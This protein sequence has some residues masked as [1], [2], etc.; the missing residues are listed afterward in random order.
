MILALVIAC[1][2]GGTEGAPSPVPSAAVAGPPGGHAPMGGM[3]GGA[4]AEDLAGSWDVSLAAEVPALQDAAT[5]PDAD[6]DGATDAW[7]CPLSGTDC[8]DADPRVTPE[9]ERWVRPGPFLMG[10]TS[11]QAG[12]DEGPVHVVQLSGYCLDRRERIGTDGALVAGVDRSAA[13]TMCEADGKT[14]PTEA[15]WEK[16]ARGG[17]EL[18]SDAARCDTGDLRP[19]PWGFDVPACARANHQESTGAPRMCEGGATLAVRNTGPYGHDELAGNLWE[20]TLDRYHPQVYRRAPARVD[21]LGPA[22]GDLHVLRGGGWNTF[23]T[24][25]RVANRL[26][27]NLE[28]T[29]T[30][31]RCARVRAKGTYDEVAPLEVVTISGEVRGGEGPL[32]GAALYVTAFD[33]SDADPA[34]GAVAPGRSPA[35]E[36]RLTPNGASTVPFRLEVPVDGT[37]VVMGALDGGAPL[38]TN[39]QWVAQSGAGGMGRAEP[40][41]VRVG[42]DDVSAVV[43]TIRAFE[44]GGPPGEG[45]PGRGPVPPPSPPNAGR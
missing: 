16:A 8:D 6:G 12:R 15:Q 2:S 29:A 20:W 36:V 42:R 19:Y 40:N 24:N 5:C 31:V 7:T 28:G 23:S 4:G 13:K 41:P 33:A 30:G 3:P 21:P 18:G 32:V 27:S 11:S 37:Y 1:S 25:M 39:G 17:C 9:T 35:A 14:L 45:P 22:E 34:T 44:G 38:Q 26:S 43:V 10:S